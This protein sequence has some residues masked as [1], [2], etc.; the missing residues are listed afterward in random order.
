MFRYICILFHLLI[1]VRVTKQ[2]IAQ[3]RSIDSLLVLLGKDG[4]DTGKVNHLNQLSREYTNISSYDSALRCADAALRTAGQLIFKKGM[5]QSYSNIGRAHESQGNYSKAMDAYFQA[6]DICEGLGMKKG[7]EVC[8][9]NIGNVYWYRGDY[10]KALDYSIKALKIAEEIGD[11]SGIARYLDNIGI[12]YH[13]TKNY[14]KALE[15]YSRALKIAEEAGDSREMAVILVNT[16]TVYGEQKEY[17]RALGHFSMA[18]K[19]YEDFGS[20]NLIAICLG[21]IGNIYQDIGASDKALESHLAALKIQEEIGDLKGIALSC[22]NIG[23]IYTGKAGYPDAIEYLQK[24]LRISRKIGTKDLA[25][26]ACRELSETFEKAE[27][28]KNAYQYH[29]LYSLIKDSIFSRE[30]GNQITEMQAKYETEK[31]DQELQLQQLLIQKKNFQ[32]YGLLGGSALILAISVLLMQQFRSRSKRRTLEL[33]QK[34]LRSQMNPHFLFNSLF[35]IQ[36]FMLENNPDDAAVYLSKFAELMRQILD[37]SREEYIPIQKEIKTLENY[38]ELQKLRY[39][40]RFEFRI[41][42]DEK[43]DAEFTSIPPMLAQPFIENAIEHGLSG[44]PSGG[45]IVVSF[46]KQQKNILFAVQDN[47]IGIA[48]AERTKAAVLKNYKS[49]ATAI[50]R[51]R[52]YVLNKR[53]RKKIIFSIESAP[54]QGGDYRRG[55]KVSFLIPCRNI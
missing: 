26:N 7:M 41:I 25:M 9:G 8:M 16:G 30:T 42:L 55:T 5:A 48:E 14:P 21:N 43:I 13:G 52:L 35:S 29:Q 18:L 23:D 1:I 33:Q 53:K 31:K 3:N 28:F 32:I 27:D 39:E 46:S 38:L 37:N 36:S 12:I 24:A 50:T 49:L 34:L 45:E 44:L 10:S 15:Y 2:S 19:I 17:S 20:K 6:L 51:E 47:G 22:I 11:K 54:M 40:N 4:A